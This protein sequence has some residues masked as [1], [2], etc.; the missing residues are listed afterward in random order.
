MKYSHIVAFAFFLLLSTLV[1]NAQNPYADGSVLPGGTNINQRWSIGAGTNVT[2]AGDFQ[3]SADGTIRGHFTV[4]GTFTNSGW[5]GDRIL[6][7]AVLE[8]FGD[9]HSYQQIR[10][11]EGGTLIV[12]GN[13]TNYGGGSTRLSGNVIVGGDVYMRNADVSASGNIV[14]GGNLTIPGGGGRVNGD[15]YVMDPDASVSIPGWMPVTTGDETDYETDEADNTDLNDAVKDVGLVSSV[16]APTGFTFSALAG[17]SVD[18]QWSL[19]AATDSVMIAWSESDLKDRPVDGSNYEVGANLSSGADIVYKGKLENWTFNGLTPGVTSYFRIWSYNHPEKL[20]SKAVKLTVKALSVDNILYENFESGRNSWNLGTHWSGNRWEVGSAEAYMGSSS[21]YVSNDG[22]TT[23]GYR[24]D[25]SSTIYLEKSVD[26]PSNY[27]SLELTFYWKCIGEVGYDGGSVRENRGT[28]LV[29]D[30]SLAGQAIWVEEVVDISQYIGTRFDLSFRWYNDALAGQG[31]GLCI[32]EVRITGSEVARPQSF[33]GV[34]N[35]AGQIDLS[36][37]KSVEDDNVVIAYS[38]Y[39]SIGR[40]ESGKSYAVGD[41]FDGGGQ[42]IYVGSATSYSHVGSFTGTLNYRIWSEKAGAYSSALPLDVSIPVM[43]PFVEDFE[44]DVSVWNFNSGYDNAWVRGKATAAEGTQSAYISNDFGVT[45]GY[46]GGSSADTY[47]ELEVD[48]R[49]YETAQMTFDWK[50]N[51]S[52]NNSGRVYV[53]GTMQRGANAVNQGRYYD[54]TSWQPE[55]ISLNGYTDGIHTI[56]FRWENNTWNAAENPGFCIDNVNITGT[57]ADPNSF[58]ADNPNALYNNLTWTKN[59]YGDDVLV[60]WASDGII[61]TPEVGMIYM[62]GDV[63]PGGGT[64]LYHGDALTYKHEPLKYSTSYSYKAWSSRNGL[65]STGVERI[66]N[67]PAKVT[68]LEEYWEDGDYS[69]WTQSNDSGNNVWIISADTPATGSNA[70]C[71]SS[72]GSNAVYNN[73]DVS[74]ARL[75]VQI[76][77]EELHSASLSFD[78]RCLGEVNY[79]YGEV[80]L[81]GNLISLTGEYVDN[82]S[83]SSE[84]IDLKAY[85]GIV[86]SQTLEFIWVNDHNT[87]GNPGF[88]IDNIEVGGIYEPTSIVDNGVRLV[89]SVSSMA[90]DA[91]NG[92]DVFSF[93]LTDKNSK[94][95][96]ITRIQQITVSKGVANTIAKWN[97]ALAGAVLL[98]PDLPSN[99]LAGVITSSGITFTGTDFITLDVQDVAENYTLNVWLKPD[100]VTAGI[101]DNAIFDFVVSGADIVTSLGDDF[102]NAYKVQSGAVSIDVQGTQ[103][104]FTQQPSEQATFNYLLSRIAEVSVVD[105]NGNVDVDFTG[106]LAFT[107][108]SGIAMVSNTAICNNGVASFSNLLFTGS[109]SAKLNLDVAYSGLIA[110]QSDEIT[111]GDYCIPNHSNNN[112]FI[113]KVMLNTIDNTTGKNAT[114]YE[115]YL[116]QSTD[117]SIGASYDLTVVVYNQNSTRRY[118]YVWIDSNGNGS[119]EAAERTLIDNT[120]VNGATDILQSTITINGDANNFTG[121]TRMRIQF[122]ENGNPD[123]CSANV[124]ESEDYTV[125]LTTEGWQ[126]QNNIWGASQN[127]TSGTVPDGNTDVFI[128]E[129][130]LFGKRFPIITGDANMKNLEIS[131]NAKLTIQPG[132]SVNITGDIKNEGEL[133]IENTSSLPASVIYSGAAQANATV[134]WAYGNTRWWFVGHSI[135]NPQMDSYRTILSA[136]PSNKFAMFDYQDPGRLARISSNNA[137]NFPLNDEI[138]GYQLKVLNDATGVSQTGTLNNASVYEK[139]VQTGWQIIANPYASYYQLPTDPS[140]SSDFANTIGSV[141]IT[142]ATTNQDKV[143]QTFNTN[144]GISSPSSFN[145]VIAPSQAFYIKTVDNPAPGDKL[146]MRAS[147]R[148]HDSGKSALKSLRTSNNKLI[149]V[150]VNNEHGIEDEAVIA[151]RGD[152]DLSITPLDSEQRFHSGT[153]VSYVYSIIDGTKTVINVL[154]DHLKTHQQNLGVQLKEG[155]QTIEIDGLEQLNEAYDVV[156]E[157]RVSG[158]STSMSDGAS[159]SF[160]SEE[161][162]FDDRFVLHFNE[163]KVPTAVEDIDKNGISGDVSVYIQNESTL[164]ITCDWDV[165]EKMVS[166]YAIT[167]QQVYKEVFEGRRFTNTLSLHTGVYV[168]KVSGQGKVYETKVVVR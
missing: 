158:I 71:I 83:W 85:C 128:P 82:A 72:N 159:Y 30:A 60:A 17:A 29:P 52:Y 92:V 151:F 50:V 99:G 27:K 111:I 127:W 7:G 67:T 108:A 34:A 14:V 89:S 35:P 40:P 15:I 93:D 73:S 55:T 95:K 101:E 18:L 106:T 6:D 126:G 13:F 105:A 142:E 62:E 112:S 132:A 135:S 97:D 69:E 146:Y 139:D 51:G 44:G 63:I 148:V 78:W 100:L 56:R 2:C 65:Y 49:G 8:I 147:N 25:R 66:A 162:T 153:N 54:R 121:A 156:L 37:Q 42:V 84:R 144:S 154:P 124:G 41:Y 125:V 53:D 157:D 68:V 103:L 28:R 23:A 43:L 38:P 10:V 21:A 3:S 155:E 140:A 46:D 166:V 94:Y 129:T 161:G 33:S 9:F 64:V 20:Y 48:L 47:L 90:N 102:I 123:A 98:G 58:G 116:E 113:Q 160:K 143:Y 117:L 109:G 136:D 138:R 119:F 36:W 163:V 24:D 131:S 87:G 76:D 80:Y 104:A 91:I 150:K 5:S 88:C 130:P 22:G 31:P 96:D 12:H 134:N 75:S 16:D 107:N 26:I 149:R 61:G 81:G 59:N 11:N 164:S 167:G 19:N 79:D 74:I 77:L 4:N 115:Q 120:R 39:G 122:V 57:I 133:L 70:A 118:L 152:G 165:Q 45:A 141:Y 168:I 86:G 137:Y 1:G 114:V 145:G 110:A 32:D